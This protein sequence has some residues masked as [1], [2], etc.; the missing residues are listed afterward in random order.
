MKYRQYLHPP[1][2]SK[3]A[4]ALIE[5][6]GS[7]YDHPMKKIKKVR[8]TGSVKDYQVI[9]ER[10]LTGVNLSE[11]NAISCYLGKL[12]KKLNMV[13]KIENPR[14]LSQVYKS[15]RMQEAYLEAMKQ[16]IQNFSHNR[17]YD[18]RFQ[19]K[20]PL[21]P[22]PTSNAVAP[23][24]K[25]VSIRTLRKKFKW[26]CYFC[27]KKTLRVIGYHSN[28][29]LHILMDTGSSHNFIDPEV[30]KEIGCQVSSTTPQAVTRANGNDI[31]G[32]YNG[33]LV[34]MEKA[35]SQMSRHTNQ[36]H[37]SWKVS[38][39]INAIQMT[40]YEALYGRPPPLHLPYLPGESASIEVDATL[41]NR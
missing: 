36:D 1:K 38:K 10:H 13:V 19:S 18:Q 40:P 15:T 9:F 29:P 23:I 2:W 34:Q 20:P 28:K 12:N 24:S 14:T 16:P 22:T 41:L 11:K 25:G 8:Q 33:V 30:V 7:D 39:D 27:N 17:R 26:L 6:F 32:S 3:Y 37:R 5:R 35:Y 21:L 4:M 31:E